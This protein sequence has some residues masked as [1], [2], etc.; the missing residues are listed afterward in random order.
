MQV[1][2]CQANEKICSLNIVQAN[3]G[4]YGLNSLT[5]EKQMDEGFKS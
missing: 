1:L 5:Y 2:K 4:F 3:Y